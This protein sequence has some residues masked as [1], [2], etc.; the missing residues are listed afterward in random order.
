VSCPS[1][2]FCVAIGGSG[3]YTFNGSSWS[4]AQALGSGASEP[5]AV[6]C[7]SA[8]FC[9]AVAG[10]GSVYTYN[11][12]S[13]STKPKVDVVNGEF[14]GLSGV[15]CLSTSFCMGFDQGS[16]RSLTYNGRSW[17][18]PTMVKTGQGLT[19]VSCPSASFCMAVDGATDALSWRS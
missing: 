19:S 2:S 18:A 12:T 4:S 14:L 16:N 11:G 3:A 6:S 15:S 1:A 17:S 13:W 5:V 10:D 8:S 7:P 9:V